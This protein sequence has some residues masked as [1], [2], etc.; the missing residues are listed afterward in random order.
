[1]PTFRFKREDSRALV[2]YLRAIQVH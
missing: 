1:M 2:D